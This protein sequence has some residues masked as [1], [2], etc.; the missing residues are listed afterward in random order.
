MAT[1]VLRSS[2][3]R[4][5]R[6]D[7]AHETVIAGGHGKVGLRLG[8]LLA[9][10][11]GPSRSGWSA[12][13]EQAPDLEAAGVEP[14]VLDL[15]AGHAAAAGAGP[16][17]APTRS[18]SAPAPAGAGGRRGDQRDRRRGRGPLVDAASAAGVRR[19]VWCRCSWTPAAA[20]QVSDT[21]EN[22][23]RVK[24]ASD[25]HLAA[26]DLDWTILRPGTLTDDPGTGTGA[27]RAGHRLGRRAPRRRGGR[28]GRAAAR[29]GHGAPGPRA[30]RAATRPSADAVS[31]AA[32]A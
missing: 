22:Y 14:L 30:D 7:G 1:S 19:F 8:A 12:P 6:H 23:M 28:P 17:A 5:M 18:S 15:A 13:P 9:A 31:A 4:S 29:A 21:F 32:R 2:N 3:V 25:V 10:A 11:G 24:R 26:S 20:D 27:P 16:A